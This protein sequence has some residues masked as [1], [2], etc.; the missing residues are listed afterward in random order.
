MA[1]NP[2]QSPETNSAPRST[3]PVRLRNSLVVGYPFGLLTA[4]IVINESDTGR[5]WR[6]ILVFTVGWFACSL[7]L[8]G[9]SR[10][11]NGRR[12]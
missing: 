5:L 9:I 11:W 3:K 12:G 8:L 10:W 1:E 4:I 2:Y 6:G 7:A